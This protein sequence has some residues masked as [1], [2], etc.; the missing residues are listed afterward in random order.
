MILYFVDTHKLV[1]NY[2]TIAQTY[3][4]KS[5]KFSYYNCRYKLKAGR[6][7]KLEANEKG[8]RNI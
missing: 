1:M 5:L 8:N 6:L 2:S 4:P 7:F 3:L